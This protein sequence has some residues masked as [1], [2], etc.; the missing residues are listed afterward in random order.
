[1]AG[2]ALASPRSARWFGNGQPLFAIGERINPTGKKALAESL[3]AGSLSLV[4]EFA[5]RQE[6][7]GADA[8][9][10]NVGAA[11]VDRARMLR[12]AALALPTVTELPL[13]LDE[14]D[15]AALEPALKAYPGRALVN[16]VNGGAASMDAILPLAARYGAAV[17]VLTLDDE[18]IPATA[19]ARL[20]IVARVRAAAKREGLSDRDLAVD[21]LTLTVATDPR[22][23]AVTLDAVRRVSHDLGLATVLG[24]SN[25]SHGL[26]GRQALN[27]AFLAMAGAA[28]LSAAIVNP[29]D[30]DVAEAALAVK[31]LTGTDEQAKDWIAAEKLLAEVRAAREP[32]AADVGEAAVRAERPAAGSMGDGSTADRLAS[33]VETGDAQAAPG[34]VDDVIRQGTAPD[35]VIGE[36]LTPAITR[37]GDAFGR[38]EAF[39][40]QL[41]VA[42][43]AMKAAS[44]R[45]KTYLPESAD[46]SEGRVVF[47]TVKGDIHSIGKDICVSLLESQGFEVRD[48]GVDVAPETIADAARQA[49]VVCLSA[50]MTTTLR[51]ME[52]AARLVTDEAS[53]PVLVGG[54]VVT[55]DW[56]SSIGAGYAPDA[57]G[58]VEA[59]RAAMGARR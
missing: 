58:C 20:D 9:D 22:A 37:L 52:A 34:L 29:E 57:P 43:D 10:V 47:A 50:L 49:D 19:D 11:G 51:Q 16:S 33:A 15:P 32:N 54:A 8:L 41:M 12:E 31:V 18:G 55:A 4:R 23:P 21:C 26:P 1:L 27:A 28:G 44:D 48:L 25:V 30:L 17:V 7:A 56:A 45:V 36:V 2:V 6:M 3:R 5:Q 53:V 38:G 35:R 13:V 42:A 14:T 46:H 40:P 59:V 24:V 39:L